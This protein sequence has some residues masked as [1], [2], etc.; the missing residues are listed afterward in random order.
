M[1]DDVQR[2]I[3]GAGASEGTSRPTRQTP[4]SRAD[5]GFVNIAAVPRRRWK[6]SGLHLMASVAVASLAYLLVFGLW[7]PSPYSVLSGGAALF[8]LLVS[9]DV[10]LGPALTAVVAAPVKPKVQLRRDLMVIV[11]V[12]LAGMSYGL[13]SIAEARPVAIAFE[14]DRFR[15]VAATDIDSQDLAQAE[16]ALRKLSWTGPRLIAAVK[17]VEVN[18][19]MRSIEKGLAGFDL[20]T[21]PKNWRVYANFQEKAWRV[22]RPLPQLVAKYPETADQV[23]AISSSIGVAMGDLRFLP[24]MSRRA[25]WV[26]VLAPR[27]DKIL[28]YLPVDGFF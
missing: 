16:P 9:V 23:L 25:S 22:A 28:G 20:A 10:V 15:V 14:I 1:G 26:A 24:L 27:G 6:A 3:S 18:A 13:I 12:Q 5:P 4:A 11:V 21:D 7:Y 2:Q 17:P 8:K 19:Q